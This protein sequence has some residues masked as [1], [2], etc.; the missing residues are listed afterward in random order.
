MTEQEILAKIGKLYLTRDNLIA[1][2]R[3]AEAAIN[4]LRTKLANSNE[5]KEDA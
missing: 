2:L 1:Q 3:Q 5:K 4:E